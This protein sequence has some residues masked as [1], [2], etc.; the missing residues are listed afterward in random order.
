MGYG[1][2]ARPFPQPLS[3]EHISLQHSARAR[4]VIL[5]SCPHHTCTGALRNDVPSTPHSPAH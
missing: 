5:P 4:V 3:H 1:A 2:T